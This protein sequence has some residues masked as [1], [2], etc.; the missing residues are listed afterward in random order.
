[1]TSAR[2]G[3]PERHCPAFRQARCTRACLAVPT[4]PR[5]VD[6]RYRR[7][8]G[9][10]NRGRAE[11]G[12]HVSKT[13]G[14][15][16]GATPDKIQDRIVRMTRHVSYG[17]MLTKNYSTDAGNL[18]AGCFGRLEVKHKFKLRQSSAGSS[19]FRTLLSSKNRVRAMEIEEIVTAPRSPNRSKIPRLAS[20]L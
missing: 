5:R 4:T 18:E 13:T 2:S 20:R 1:M 17:S 6:G 19:R 14:N 10:L 16:I 15:E 12:V 9:G 3:L 11:P 8:V 7:H